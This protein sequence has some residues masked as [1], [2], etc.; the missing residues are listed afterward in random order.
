MPQIEIPKLWRD[1]VCEILASGN[2][3]LIH[4]DR[5]G[6][7]RYE[8]T[9]GCDWTYEAEDAFRNYLSQARPT[10][11]RVTTMDTP[12]ETYDFFFP[13]KEQ[14]FYGKI[15]LRTDGKRLI[16]YSAHPPLRDKLFCEMDD[17]E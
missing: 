5:L 8:A 9:P 11:C 6:R 14:K 3:T 15:L 17:E 13:F 1:K 2:G 16:I 10:G 4:W 7:K 12:G